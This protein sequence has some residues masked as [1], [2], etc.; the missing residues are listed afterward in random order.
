[1]LRLIAIIF[2]CSVLPLVQAAYAQ[3]NNGAQITDL[4]NRGQLKSAAELL[5]KSNPT[6]SD[7]MFFNAR[8]LK[9][10]G[11][12]SE[13]IALFRRILQENPNYINA[14]RE[15]AHT[16]L[17]DKQY[18]PSEFHFKALL[19]VDSNSQMRMGY[20]N[21]LNTIH[22]SQ[23]IGFSGNFSLLPSTNI[24]RGSSHKK[25]NSEFLGNEDGDIDDVSRANSGIGARIG[26]SG[27]ARYLT[28]TRSRVSL[29][30]GVSETIYTNSLYNSTFGFAAVGFD[31]VT[32]SGRWGITPYLRYTQRNDHPIT[33]EIEGD[34][35]ALGAS[36]YHTSRLGNRSDLT[37]RMTR[38]RRH[39]FTKD[40]L[41]GGYSSAAL[42]FGRKISPSL[43]VDSTLKLESSTPQSEQ[44][45][46][47]GQ[48]LKFALTKSWK[49]GLSTNGSL[50]VGQRDFIGVFLGRPEPRDDK[51]FTLG[52]GVQNSSISVLGFAPRLQCS[53]TQNYSNVNFFDYEVSECNF[54]IT[55]NF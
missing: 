31:Q 36:F 21:F 45:Q 23:P 16:L 52:I 2:T 47:Q 15:L 50:E 41:N 32:S 8:V 38:E 20:Q 37:F 28:G 29:D 49:G 27:F 46:Y 35:R 6:Q 53:H 25:T 33:T 30:F 39:H 55:R 13:A 34:N 44:S 5:E 14:R 11:Q 7:I 26:V 51:Y 42:S 3:S 48:S 17:L 18:G 40:Y 22:R 12:H 1:M 10:R 9:I 43:R 19:K 24:N 4:L 54:S